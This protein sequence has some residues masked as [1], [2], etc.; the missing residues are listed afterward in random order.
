MSCRMVCVDILFSTKCGEPSSL[1]VVGLMTSPLAR[2]VEA[3]EGFFGVR[4]R[5]GM[6]SA[7][8]DEAPL[9]NDRIE[10]LESF[11]GIQGTLDL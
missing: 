9:L 1:A 8:I 7:I 10:P 2:N 4:F 6:A 3:G 5:P 11:L